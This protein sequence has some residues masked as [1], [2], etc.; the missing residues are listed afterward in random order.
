MKMTRKSHAQFDKQRDIFDI[1]EKYFLFV[2]IDKACFDIIGS[3]L[4]FI[5]YLT[6]QT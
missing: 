1:T 6:F 3:I 2:M 4:C 5:F